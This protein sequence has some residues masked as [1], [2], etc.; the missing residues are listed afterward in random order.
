MQCKCC[1]PKRVMG[2]EKK[3]FVPLLRSSSRVPPLPRS[4][5][6][7]EASAFVAASFSSEDDEDNSSSSAASSSSTRAEAAN[8]ATPLMLNRAFF[9]LFLLCPCPK[10]ILHQSHHWK[11]STGHNTFCF[12]RTTSKNSAMSQHRYFSD[13][14]SVV[15]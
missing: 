13:A 9:F 12:H 8:S 5:K 3:K 10:I 1:A 4:M 11:Q 15:D 2:I 7:G 6:K 14:R